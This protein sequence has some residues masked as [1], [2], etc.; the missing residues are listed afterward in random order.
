MR[1]RSFLSAFCGVL[2]LLLVTVF[3]S[4]Q[5][6]A[7]DGFIAVDLTPEGF[8]SSMAV[9]ASE[10]QQAGSGASPS[11]SNHALDGQR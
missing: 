6:D 11:G 5:L 10:G 3:D 4:S 9:A 8:G 7:T 1:T 2:S